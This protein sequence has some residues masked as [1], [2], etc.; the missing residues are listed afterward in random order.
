MVRI[1]R[2]VNDALISIAG[3]IVLLSVLTLV[4][5]RVRHEITLRLNPGRAQAAV[6]DAAANV[7]QAADNIVEAARDRTIEHA[8]LA[9][10]VCAAGALTFFMLRI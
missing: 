6:V 2:T 4:N 10:F 8:A 1:R 9:I 3:L 5:E 7:R